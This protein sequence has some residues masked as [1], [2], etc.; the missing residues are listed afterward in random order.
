MKVDISSYKLFSE[1]LWD[2]TPTP[3]AA[4]SMATGNCVW[5]QSI[6]RAAGSAPGFTRVLRLLL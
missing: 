5:L 3:H 4:L 6:L 1:K 2:N